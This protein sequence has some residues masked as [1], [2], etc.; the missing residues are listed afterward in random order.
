MAHKE[1]RK[2]GLYSYWM[3]HRQTNSQSG[4]CHTHW[5]THRLDNS[6]TSQSTEQKFTK[7]IELKKEYLISN[8]NFLSHFEQ[9]YPW[10]LPVSESSTLRKLTSLCLDRLQSGLSRIVWLSD[11]TNTIWYYGFFSFVWLL[12]S[13]SHFWYRSQHINVTTSTCCVVRITLRC[14]YVPELWTVNNSLTVNWFVCSCLSDWSHGFRL[15]TRL[16]CSSVLCFGS[17]F[18]VLVISKCGR[19]SWP[20]LWSTSRCTIK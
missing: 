13:K 14:G 5:S 4:N 1:I 10:I 19:L 3:I 12:Q 20:A 7:H 16:I 6:Q 15:F 9:I 11:V 17:I 2:W 8:P 18:S